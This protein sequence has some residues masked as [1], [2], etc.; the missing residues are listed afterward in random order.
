MLQF[1]VKGSNNMD[2]FSLL[3]PNNKRV[4]TSYLSNEAVNDL[5]INYICDAL[6]EDSFEKNSIKN[7]LTEITC[8]EETIKYRR[9]IFD[10]FLNYKE[11]R[12]NLTNMLS[13]LAELR[14]LERFQK[15]TDAS[16]IWQLINRLREID[17][18][19][20]C[21]SKMKDC[22]NSTP[23][24]SKG[25]LSLKKV[26]KDIHES[27]GFDLL[28]EDIDATFEKARSL[29]SITIGVNLD[30]MLRPYSAGVLALNDK[31]FSS[32]GLLKKF[33]SFA[34][35]QDE[36]NHGTD[37]TG[38]RSFHS[39][40]S[41]ASEIVF[42][43]FQTGP[44]RDA[45]IET[46]ATGGDKLSDSLKKVV[47]DILK[48]IV[49]DIKSV[50]QKYINV[51][52]Y[53]LVKLMPEIIFYIRWA[54]LIEKIKDKGLPI[55]K[56]EI[57]NS[58][59]RKLKADGIYNLKLAIKAVK[60]EDINIVTNEINFD[61]NGRI[62][63]L[64]GPNRGGKTTYTQ[65]VGLL[66]LLAQNGIYTPADSVVLSP[67]DNIF[68]HFPADENET[69]DLGRLGEE[70]QRLSNIFS[71]ATNKSLMLLNESLATTNV[72]EGVYIARDVLKSMR[73]LGCRAI[74]NT[75]MHELAVDLDNLNSSDGS[76][77]IESMIT[78]VDNGK[79]S[80]KVAIAPP[81]GVSYAKDIAEKYGVT[82]EQIK[83]AIDNK[84]N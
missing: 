23:I 26:V 52:G 18:Y 31:E 5:S 65:A 62:Y 22:L 11:L 30:D 42:G 15:D 71:I 76:S 46:T 37:F 17:G 21:I 10:D 24:K 66:F 84:M 27:G 33:M 48:K 61:D 35:N 72:A 28:K 78:G 49:K 40:Q 56:A 19:I 29:R 54:E 79:R 39:A 20:D 60:G 3:Y 45:H 2:E 32:G 12:N 75:H 70:S 1:Y 13:M 6:T 59:E 44:N 8:D 67:C 55:C 68:T 14:D 63:I 51:S 16:S 77:V 57:I 50:L 25:L 83:K 81:Q 7:I 43:N 36:L 47:T 9:D 74:F 38:L 64:T 80:F 4:M 69:V 58:Q 34:A 53:S 41:S 73:Y 82:Y